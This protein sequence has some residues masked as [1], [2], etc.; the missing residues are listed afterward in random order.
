MS[1]QSSKIRQML[2]P[3]DFS[4]IREGLGAF[5]RKCRFEK[6]YEGG[7]SQA[8]VAKRVGISRGS[9]S[10]IERG[11][12]HPCY[13]TLHELMRLYQFDWGEIATKGESLRPS[14]RYAAELRQDLGCALR[15]GRLEE[16]LTLRALAKQTG[17]SVSQL[18]RIERS[19]STRSR[20]IEIQASDR[21]RPID[22]ET[23][24]T[25]TD[26]VLARL[27]EKGKLSL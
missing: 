10:R 12:R 24:F 17:M 1:R 16:G 14:R 18:S 26:R 19:Q 22:D 11:H 7:R 13:G 6:D 20:V 2:L 27:A 25:F 9:L 3:R 23:V 4:E 21:D 8:A 5:L 15:A